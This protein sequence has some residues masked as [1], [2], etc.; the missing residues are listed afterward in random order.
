MSVCSLISQSLFEGV[1]QSELLRYLAVDERKDRGWWV[2]AGF[3]DPG[4]SV[5]TVPLIKSSC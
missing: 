4:E 1:F 2:P 3:V 5:E